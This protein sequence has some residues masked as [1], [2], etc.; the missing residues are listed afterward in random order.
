MV[1]FAERRFSVYKLPALSKTSACLRI[2]VVPAGGHMKAHPADHVLPHVNDCIASRSSQ[3]LDRFEFLDFAHGRAGGSN[4][5]GLR[6]I[7]Q[8]HVLPIF[9]VVAGS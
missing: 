6:G 3:Y 7:E 4:Q 1:S 8:R 9:V 5:L 2:I